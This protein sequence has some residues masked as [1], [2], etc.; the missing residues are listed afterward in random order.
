[1]G[2]L[3]LSSENEEVGLETFDNHTFPSDSDSPMCRSETI[4]KADPVSKC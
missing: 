1:M 3:I 4:E 2:L